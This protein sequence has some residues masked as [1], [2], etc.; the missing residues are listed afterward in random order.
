MK[1]EVF[2]LGGQIIDQ[3]SKKGWKRKEKREDWER[4]PLFLQ[5]LR[6]WQVGAQAS[7]F[8]FFKLIECITKKKI[9]HGVK[10]YAKICAIGE[11]NEIKWSLYLRRTI[12]QKRK[13]GWWR[14]RRERI[15]KGSW[16][17][18]EIERKE[19]K[20]NWVNNLKRRIRNIDTCLFLKVHFFWVPD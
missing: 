5:V 11:Q 1:L 9:C 3:K 4:E 14:E 17:R 20:G 15:E 10:Q 13:K 2:V 8:V 16:E 18:I 7:I 6:V 19:T 12:D